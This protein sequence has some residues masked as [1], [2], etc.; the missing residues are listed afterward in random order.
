[1][2]TWRIAWRNLW[3]NR[4]RT[5]LALAAIGLSVTLVLLYNGMLRG[6]GDWLV[7]TISGP[8]L[9]HVQ[10][11]D[12]DWRDTRAMERTIRDVGAKLDAI[13]RQPGVTGADARVY[14]PVLAAVG[15]DGFAVFVMGLDL[16]AEAAPNRLLADTTL[17][18]PG[19]VLVGRELATQMEVAPGDRLAIVGQGADGSLANDLFTVADVV[20][21]SVDFV[22]RKAVVT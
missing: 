15:V 16:Q 7:A 4:R 8:M 10:V 22:N 12:P 3:R 2:T 20:T 18:P 19:Q 13:R 5:G 1:M 6:Y 9:G 14:A 11:H 21:T 17:P